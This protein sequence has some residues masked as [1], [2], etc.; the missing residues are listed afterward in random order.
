MFVHI[1]TIIFLILH[2]MYFFAI[3][4]LEVLAS[5]HLNEMKIVQEMLDGRCGFNVD[6]EIVEPTSEVMPTIYW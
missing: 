2:L 5:I 1:L 6:L 4:R 3:L